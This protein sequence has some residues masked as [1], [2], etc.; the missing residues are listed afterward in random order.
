VLIN[1]P[2]SATSLIN[3][4]SGVKAQLLR[5]NETPPSDAIVPIRWSVLSLWRCEV[6]DEDKK[7]E[8]RLQLFLPD[9]TTTEFDVVVPFTMK[10]Q[11]H[12]V[13]TEFI[14]FLISTP[15]VCR[16]VASLREEGQQAWTEISTYDLLV[17]HVQ[18]DA[19]L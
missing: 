16:L 3:I 9:G 12:K 4:M 15:G 2:D 8:Q 14:G 13:R 1:Q 7:F 6:G 10:G 5:P 17:E 11:T 19:P 18:P